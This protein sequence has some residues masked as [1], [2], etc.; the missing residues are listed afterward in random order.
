MTGALDLSI[1]LCGADRHFNADEMFA[2]NDQF[3]LIEFKSNRHNLGKE[4]S[5]ES[6]CLL[7]ENLIHIQEA[8][9]LHRQCHFAMWG[10][11]HRGGGLETLGGI[12][13]DLVCHPD[14]LPSCEAVFAT[15]NLVDETA[16][17]FKGE[18]LA[19]SVAQG[20]AGLHADEFALYLQW[21]LSLR[22]GETRRQN[23]P[24]VLFGISMLGPVDSYAFDSFHELAGWAN[25]GLVPE[26]NPED[27]PDEENT[28]RHDEP[29]F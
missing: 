29:R 21:L 17:V 23:F 16:L 20:K 10:K 13:Q 1:P 12:Y 5:K 4:N 26:P 22:G 6:A 15:T 11:K 25:L 14:V 27:E 24:I 7:C 3:L 18:A 9:L 19:R 8:R 2:A 28:I